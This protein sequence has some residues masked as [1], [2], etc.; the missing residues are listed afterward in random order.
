MSVCNAYLAR[1]LSSNEPSYR[2]FVNRLLVIGLA[3]FSVSGCTGLA[4]LPDPASLVPIQ[5]KVKV[6]TDWQTQLQLT[7]LQ[8][9]WFASASTTGLQPVRKGD[10]LYAAAGDQVAAIDAAAGSINW[11]QSLSDVIAAGI[12]TTDNHLVV[13]TQDGQL[14]LL[15][16]DQGDIVWS[17]T[18]TSETLSIPQ[19][20]ASRLLVQTIDGRL[21]AYAIKDG[22]EIWSY[23]SRLPSLTLRGGSDPLINDGLVYAGFA[24]G[25]LVALDVI[26]GDLVWQ[27]T[28]GLTSSF[29]LDRLADI[30][31]GLGWYDGVIYASNFQGELAALDA[32]SGRIIWTQPAERIVAIEVTQHRLFGLDQRGIIQAYDRKT[33]DP[34]WQNDE[35]LNRGMTH[36]VAYQDWLLAFDRLGYLHLLDASSGELVGRQRTG[37]TSAQVG[38]LSTADLLYIV[39]PRGKAKKLALQ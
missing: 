37:Q 12:G 20:D 10:Q 14:H 21:T 6:A 26:T 28:L 30:D 38:V 1:L 19:A 32:L 7:N 16:Q 5:A 25:K 35:L 33:G 15:D 29:D 13:G 4:S 27:R 11:Q 3:I 24:S 9:N 18:T 39:M 31:S 34:V 8:P 2:F 36:L 17:I 22:A 23:A